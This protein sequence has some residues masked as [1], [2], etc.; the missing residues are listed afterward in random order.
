M[1]L[2]RSPRRPRVPMRQAEWLE[3]RTA[4]LQELCPMTDEEFQDEA[5]PER[6]ALGP[7]EQP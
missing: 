5:G 4:E 7:E 1:A 3:T 6:P 2:N